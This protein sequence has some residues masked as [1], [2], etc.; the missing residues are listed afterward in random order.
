MEFFGHLS[1]V[2]FKVFNRNHQSRI[3]IATASVAMIILGM[4]FLH[5]CTERNPQK[6][7]GKSCSVD[8]EAI[9]SIVEK[10]KIIRA[11]ATEDC[12]TIAY[13]NETRVGYEYQLWLNVIS[14]FEGD[15]R[16]LYGLNLCGEFEVCTVLDTLI[17]LVEIDGRSF[18]FV[19]IEHGYLGTA[20]IGYEEMNFAFL[21]L[22]KNTT[23]IIGFGKH[24]N[25]IGSYSFENMPSHNYHKFLEIINPII[26]SYFKPYRVENIN[27]ENQFVIK[28]LIE[29][30]DIYNRVERDTESWHE[31]K[32]TKYSAAFFEEWV[33]NSHADVLTNEEWTAVTGFVMPVVVKS[34]DSDSCLVV[35]IPQG[36][37]NGAGWGA[38]S[39][40]FLGLNGDRLTISN[41]FE[42]LF[43]DIGD[44]QVKRMQA[45]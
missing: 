11:V 19:P 25:S 42:I 7:N 38:R 37:P 23:S 44:S 43:I 39:Y 35:W 21:D 14:D 34:I 22:T 17:S 15:W 4:C 31:L 20:F 30:E 10:K 8:A 28:W 13:L 16:K 18:L 40:K 6:S 45:K 2:G 27:N 3:I 36:Y 24:Q 5:S 26:K 41:G 29:S 12:K 1:E 32:F 9:A 33:N